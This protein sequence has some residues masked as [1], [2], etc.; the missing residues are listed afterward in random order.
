M[1]CKVTHCVGRVSA[2]T[3]PHQLCWGDRETGTAVSHTKCSQVAIQKAGRSF[4]KASSLRAAVFHMHIH[5]QTT[6]SVY[7]HMRISMLVM[8]F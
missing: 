4:S 1:L 7:M 8:Q 6:H 5:P 3:R 2:N